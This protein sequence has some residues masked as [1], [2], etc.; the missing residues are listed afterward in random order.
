MPA[1]VKKQIPISAGG[2]EVKATGVGNKGRG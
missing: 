2:I 1:D